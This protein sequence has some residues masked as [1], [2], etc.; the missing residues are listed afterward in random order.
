MFASHYS[1]RFSL[2]TSSKVIHVCILCIL[3]LLP[4]KTCFLWRQNLQRQYEGNTEDSFI[5]LFSFGFPVNFSALLADLTVSFWYPGHDSN[6]YHCNNCDSDNVHHHHYSY[7]F[8]GW[9]A[10]NHV[11]DLAVLAVKICQVIKLNQTCARFQDPPNPI[12]ANTR[13]R[14]VQECSILFP[15]RPKQSSKMLWQELG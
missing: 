1:S 11:P 8:A 12:Q 10:H 14:K 6:L 4:K 15:F 9:V 2:E 3:E 5:S 13:S 7:D